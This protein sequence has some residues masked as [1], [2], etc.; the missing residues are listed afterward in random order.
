MAVDSTTTGRDA[1][2]AHLSAAKRQ[3]LEERLRRS[4]ATA[5]AGIPRRPDGEAPPL[6]YAQERL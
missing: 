6:S 3:L 2:T 1:R 5:P 4:T